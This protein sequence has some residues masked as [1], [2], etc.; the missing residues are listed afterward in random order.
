MFLILCVLALNAD[1]IVS[2]RAAVLIN[3][4]WVYQ[5]SKLKIYS[6]NKNLVV[7]I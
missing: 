6:E 4:K 3:N 7:T 2:F 1:S 5:S